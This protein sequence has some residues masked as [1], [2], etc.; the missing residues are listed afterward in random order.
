MIQKFLS[1]DPYSTFSNP[2]NTCLIDHNGKEI[3]DTES[4]FNLGIEAY[5]NIGEF[6]SKEIFDEIIT[7]YQEIVDEWREI[8]QQKN[9]RG[10]TRCGKIFELDWCKAEDSQIVNVGWK[11]ASDK[12]LQKMN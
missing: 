6:Q 3:S 10:I 12:K 4:L 11:I 5:K 2:I 8:F 7:A 9:I 1:Y